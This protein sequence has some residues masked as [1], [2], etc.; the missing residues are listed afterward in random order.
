MLR[1]GLLAITLLALAQTGVALAQEAGDEAAEGEGHAAEH[2]HGGPV[3]FSDIVHNTE[4]WGACIN[5]TLLLVVLRKLGKKPLA[6]FLIQRRREMEQNM[7]EAAEMKAK[8]EARYKEYTQ[9]IAQLD[10]ELVKLEGDIARGAEEDKLRIIA[11]AQDAATRLK[12][13]TEALIERYAR[14]LGT[15][16]RQELVAAAV[17]AAEKVLREAVN[18]DDQQKLAERYRVEVASTN[19]GAGAAREGR[20]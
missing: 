12:R 3:H 19:R 16:V 10:Q 14:A 2:E 7:A 4:F 15:E 11:D 6:D 13:D 20:S 5:F 9:R 17:A 1:A 8:A 18:A